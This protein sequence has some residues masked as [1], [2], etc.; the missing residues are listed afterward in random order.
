MIRSIKVLAVFAMVCLATSIYGQPYAG[1]FAGL[2]FGKLTGDVPQYGSFKSLP[3]VNAGVTM[4]FKIAGSVWL[5]LQ[6]SYSQEGTRISYTFR[7]ETESIDSIHIRLTYFSIPLMVKVTAANERFYGIAG[8]ETGYLLSK[9]LT[10]DDEEFEFAN[11]VA[12][13][14][15]AVHFGVGMKIPIGFPRLFIELRYTQ[16]LIN[17]TDDPVEFSY[18]PRV[19]TNGFKFLAGIEFPLKKTSK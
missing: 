17:L 4:D 5:S 9:K 8:V 19:K 15:V 13:W 11:D 7:G 3:G 16:G 2:N 14:N 18:I 12:E 1:A 10:S 6:P